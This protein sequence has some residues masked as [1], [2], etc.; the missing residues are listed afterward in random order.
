MTTLADKPNFLLI[1]TDQQRWDHFGFMGNRVLRTPNLD[2]LAARGTCFT[3]LYVASPTCMSNRAALATGRMPSQNGVRYNGVPLDRDFVT[4]VDLMNAAG[5]AT[6]LIGKSHLQGMSSSASLVP[7]GPRLEALQAP[8]AH[9]TEARRSFPRKADYAMEFREEWWMRAKEK[10]QEFESPYYGFEHV[11]LC[12]GHGD[13][14]TGHYECWLEERFPHL[15]Q[16]RGKAHAVDRGS[17]G[18]AQVYRP[19]MPEE[20]YPTTF[21]A[22]RTIEWLRRHQRERVGRPFMIQCSFP[23]PH[24]PFTPPGRYWDM[25]DAS[26]VKLPLSFHAPAREAIPPLARLWQDFERR[27]PEARWTYPFVANEA[28]AREM[29]AKTYGQITMIDDAIG[30]VLNELDRLGL[31]ANTV[32]CFLSDHG[33]YLGDHG[34]MLKGPMHY[35]S[36][37]RTPCIWA[38]PARPGP[39]SIESLAS[40]IDVPTTILSRAGLEGF[41][42]MQ[43][44]SLLPLLDGSEGAVRDAVVVE[45]TTQYAYLGFDDITTVHTIFDGSHR[46]SVW[47]GCE[48]GELYNLIE[49]P[50]ETLNLWND[51]AYAELR[52][53]MVLKLIRELQ[54]LSERSP[55]P[56]SVS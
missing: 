28:Q 52:T 16:I 15:L 26:E 23:D 56:S 36:L 27:E 46:L 3:H 12:I 29:L 21:V 25:Y 39:T 45:Q 40:T 19:A 43:G 34:L 54:E 13:D 49:D 20:A 18:H 8:P 17:A 44:V 38:D 31:S 41:N 32:I 35:Q 2:L 10:A 9:L 11:E 14:M 30:R 1:M 37:I 24:H 48:W 42:G 53:R 7:Q 4:F 51:P 5:Y 50:H 6:A 47:K 33:E 55:Y 22:E